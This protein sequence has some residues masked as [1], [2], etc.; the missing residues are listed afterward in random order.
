MHQHQS[1]TKHTSSKTI[2]SGVTNTDSILL[3]LELGNRA[4]GSE[5]LLLHNLH[6]L[7]DVGENGWL[8]EV[9]NIAVA[10]ATSLDL[11]ASFLSLVD[12]GHDAVE[13]E[14]GDLGTLECILLE[15]ISD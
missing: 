5:N 12:V 3:S 7:G 4:D 6:V 2:G 14:L 10:L 9:A 1:T 15:W 11:G 8:D 13:L